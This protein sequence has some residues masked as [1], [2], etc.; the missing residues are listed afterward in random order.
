M[1]Y[2]HFIAGS[3]LISRVHGYVVMFVGELVCVLHSLHC[4]ISTHF[5]CSWVCGDVCGRACVCPT[6]TSLPDL[7]SFH[8]FMGMW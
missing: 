6:F 7:Y 3:L 8:V 5:T 2:I 4:R 1:S